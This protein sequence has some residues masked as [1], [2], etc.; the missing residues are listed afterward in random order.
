MPTDGFVSRATH[1]ISADLGRLHPIVLLYLLSVIIP[2]G[3]NIGT[4][5]LTELRL[6]LLVLFVPL[7]FRVYVSRIDRIYPVDIFFLLH[8]LWM[9]VAIGVNNPNNVVQNAGSTS[10]EFLGG[11]LVG[12]VYIRSAADMF[13]LIRTLIALTVMSL[14][15]AIPESI[16]G[17][18]I[19][20]DWIRRVSWLTTVDQTNI[21]ERMGLNRAQVYFAH[22]IHYG[23]F[24]STAFALTLVGLRNV[25]SGGKRFLFAALIGLGVFLS[26]SSGALLSVALQLGLIIWS[27]LLRNNPNRWKILLGLFALLY[28][29][30]D[31]ASNRTP[32]KVFMSYATFSAHNAYYRSIIFDWGMVNVN[33]NPIFGLGLRDWIRP[34]YMGSGSV[35]NFW[36]VMAM[37]YGYPGFALI[38]AGYL[39]ALFS[40]GRRKLSPSTP[41]ASLRLGWMIMF[42]GLSFT[43]S[44]VHIWTAVYSF[45]FFLM[46]AGMWLASA[47]DVDIAPPSLDYTDRGLLWSRTS[48]I[49]KNGSH[50]WSRS[51]PRD[52][53]AVPDR[54]TDAETSQ[55]T[56]AC[57]DNHAP[58]ADSTSAPIRQGPI[59]TRFPNAHR[60]P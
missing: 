4:V 44:T 39:A 14:A 47:S 20:P 31:L 6:L 35:D 52:T 51:I 18:A 50:L 22:P 46:G 12:R 36:L 53:T 29:A 8:V 28:V 58:S 2:V 42:I 25:M 26:L 9:F 60:R 37:R 40:V 11:Y 30:I 1:Q 55:P 54:P 21:P 38:A 10:L 27:H 15:F 56:P 17:T 7:A 48:D 45:V 32:L 34:H 5:A 23:L 43:L 19:I 49:S 16:N 3:F 33:N 24:C 57:T 13:A 59:L 41:Q